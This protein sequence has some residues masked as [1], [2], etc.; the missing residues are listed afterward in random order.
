MEAMERHSEEVEAY[1][2]HL[3]AQV[4]ARNTRWA[5]SQMVNP[6]PTA[7]RKHI[8]IASEAIKLDAQGWG[9]Q[10]TWARTPQEGRY[11]QYTMYRVI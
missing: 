11:Y 5:R 8:K 2:A 9:R 7:L 6:H 1:S 3:K 10:S 4:E